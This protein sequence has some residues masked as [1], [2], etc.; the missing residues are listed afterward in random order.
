M[1]SVAIEAGGDAAMQLESTEAAFDAIAFR[2]Q[3]FVVPVLVSAVALG[4]NDRLHS[5]GASQ[6]ANRIGIVA[7]IGDYRLGGLSGQQRRGA[8]AVGLLPA[9]QQQ[10]QWSAQGITQQMNLGGQSATGSPQ[11]LLA[12]PLFPVAAC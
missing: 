1:G 3:R 8:L 11:S 2:I 9:G 6:R 10:P 5:F 7:F 12:R 4:R